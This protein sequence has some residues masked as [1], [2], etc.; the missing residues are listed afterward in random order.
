MEIV[1]FTLNAIVIYFVSDW[2][3]GFIE[4][5]RGGILPQRQVE[6][7]VII[8]ALALVSFQMLKQLFR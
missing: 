2:I 7:F 8:L 4:R 6:F 1:V 3:V 5:R